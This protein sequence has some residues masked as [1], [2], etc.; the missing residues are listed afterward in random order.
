MSPPSSASKSYV[1]AY[2]PQEVTEIMVGVGMHKKQQHL[3]VIIAKSFLAG[4]FLSFSGLMTLFVG[5]GTPG[6]EA[7]YPAARAMLQAFFYPIGLVFIVLTGAEL[8]TSNM[9]V[10]TITCLQRK[11]TLLDLAKSW[12]ISWL[13]NLAGSFFVGFILCYWAGILG[14]D[15]YMSY[16]IEFTNMHLTNLTFRQIFLRAIAANWLVCLAVFM[17]TSAKDIFSKIVAIF[18]PVWLF[19][20]VGYEHIVANMFLVQMGMYYGAPLS[21]GE[22]IWKGMIPVTLGNIVGGGGFVGAV[23][24]YLYLYRHSEGSSI[25][26]VVVDSIMESGANDEYEKRFKCRCHHHN[27]FAKSGRARADEEEMYFQNVSGANTPHE[28]PVLHGQSPAPSIGL[29]A[30]AKTNSSGEIPKEKP[31][32][33]M[34]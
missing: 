7:N 1:D 31:A 33:H 21:V 14:K 4:V 10:F 25:G 16:T 20:T 6:L 17:S 9:M 28:L 23:F 34:N 29:S 22:Y 2:S 13:G 26:G 11:A 32:N 15:P 3:D 24:W 19:V 30:T 18:L 12:T 5:G 27:F 8:V